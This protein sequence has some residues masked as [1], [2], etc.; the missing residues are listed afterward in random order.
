MKSE[1]LIREQVDSTVLQETGPLRNDPPKKQNSLSELIEG[2][3]RIREEDGFLISI[4]RLEALVDF[5]WTQAEPL[6]GQYSNGGQPRV[7]AFSLAK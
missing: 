6:L 3:Q 4:E 7:A 5:Y 1:T 2:A